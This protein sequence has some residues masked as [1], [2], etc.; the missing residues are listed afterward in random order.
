MHCPSCGNE[1]SLDQKF[2][3]KCG[4]NLEPVGKLMASG[5][6]EAELKQNRTEQEKVAV[7]R[8]VSWMMWGMLILLI[9][10][11]LSVIGKQFQLD[12]LVGLIGTFLILGGLA[13]TTYGVLDA[14]RGGAGFRKRET[15][16]EPSML[17][18]DRVPT[19]K[20]LEGRS[21]IP[22]PS[23]TERTTQLISEEARGNNDQAGSRS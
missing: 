21:P 14:M 23:V 15:S 18:P 11:V 8:M 3:R 5:A 10:I 9:G 16:R 22:L 17:E 19:T 6:T 1:S 7:R 12:R 2:C 20:D 4:F 13:V